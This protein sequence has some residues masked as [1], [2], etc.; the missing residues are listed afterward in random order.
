MLFVYKLS[1]KSSYIL[2][3]NYKNK[4]TL[5]VLIIARLNY[6]KIIETIFTLNFMSKTE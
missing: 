5:L 3:T 4:Y 2:F 1:V 6:L